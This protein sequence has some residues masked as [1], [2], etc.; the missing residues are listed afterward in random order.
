LTRRLPEK[1]KNASNTKASDHAEVGPKTLARIETQRNLAKVGVV[2]SNL[3]ARS[4]NTL[5]TDG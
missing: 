3:I 1:Q 2:S 5:R 4:K